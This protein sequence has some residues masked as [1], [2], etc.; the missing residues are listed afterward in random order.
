MTVTVFERIPDL[1][2]ELYDFQFRVWARDFRKRGPRQAI[3]FQRP[4]GAPLELDE[5]ARVIQHGAWLVAE[6]QGDGVMKIRPAT[7][8][9]AELIA[10][11][12]HEM[13]G[14]VLQ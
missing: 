9:D 11:H 3:L 13:R 5:E 1:F 8:Q 14:L 7:E 10:R 12:C 4:P 6:P 2:V